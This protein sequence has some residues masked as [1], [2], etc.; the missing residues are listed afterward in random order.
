MRAVEEGLPL[1]RAANSGISAIV[2]PYGRVVA[3]LALERHGVIDG[4]LP[5]ALPSTL[6]H[7]IGRWPFL[8]FLLICVAIAVAVRAGI[9]RVQRN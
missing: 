3:S 9:V 7:A 5:A 6:V 8:G 2:D 1:V 4:D